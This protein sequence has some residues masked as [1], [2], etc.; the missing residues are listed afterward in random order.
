MLGDPHW[1]IDSKRQLKYTGPPSR[2]GKRLYRD[3]K[4]TEFID[5]QGRKR[6][7]IESDDEEEPLDRE[8]MFMREFGQVRQRI[9]IFQPRPLV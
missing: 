6:H 2:M 9:D 1:V 7:V 3:F 8:D 5:K 4:P